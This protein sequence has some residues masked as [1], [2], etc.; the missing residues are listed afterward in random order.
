VRAPVL[1]KATDPLFSDRL[2]FRRSA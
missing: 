2:V 1:E